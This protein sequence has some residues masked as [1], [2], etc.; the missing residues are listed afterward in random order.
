MERKLH[1]YAGN[2]VNIH[3]F[4]RPEEHPLSS[5]RCSFLTNHVV[6][7]RAPFSSKSCPRHCLLAQ[8]RVLDLRWPV[9]IA[10]P[11]LCLMDHIGWIRALPWDFWPW[12]QRDQVLVALWRRN[13]E[14]WAIGTPES[15]ASCHVDHGN[16][17]E[18]KV[19]LWRKTKTR[20]RV[21]LV[22]VRIWAQRISALLVFCESSLNSPC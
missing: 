21:N 9:R 8:G 1:G 17:R 6:H 2:P 20:D 11:Q 22:S 4:T 5:S 3:C 10:H 19:D 7:M 16:L 15:H 13:C 12:D 14:R 18:N